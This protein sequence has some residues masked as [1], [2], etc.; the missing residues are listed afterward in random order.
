MYIR[1]P[2]TTFATR[3]KNFF[4]CLFCK[5]KKECPVSFGSRITIHYS[6]PGEYSSDFYHKNLCEKEGKSYRYSI[7]RERVATILQLTAYL[8]FFIF[9]AIGVI[10]AIT[11][12]EILLICT[13]IGFFV[14]IILAVIWYKIAT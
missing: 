13:L 14:S 4:E 7:Y 10:G 9:T 5:H 3:I 12:N 6:I 11:K 1:K 8:L 2:K